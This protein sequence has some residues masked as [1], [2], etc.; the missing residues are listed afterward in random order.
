MVQEETLNMRNRARAGSWTWMGAA[1]LCAAM[2]GFPLTPARAGGGEPRAEAPPVAQA[3]TPPAPPIPG[4]PRMAG[5]PPR[6][7]HAPHAPGLPRRM[8]D[9]DD[10]APRVSIDTVFVVRPGMR[11]AVFNF[12]GTVAF[13]TWPRNA[14]RLA[15]ERAAEDRVAIARSGPELK[16]ESVSANGQPDD[17]D[18]ALTVP[19]WL[20]VSLTGVNSDVTAEGMAGG[21][22]VET[23]HGD[24]VV[25]HVTGAVGLHSVEGV[26]DLADAHGKIDVGSVNDAV[27]LSDITGDISADAVNGDVHLVGVDSR[28]VDATSVSGDVVYDAPLQLGGTYSFSTHDGDIAVGLPDPPNAIVNVSTFSGDFASAFAIKP[29]RSV[30]GKI[31]HFTLGDGRAKLNLE[32]FEGSIELLRL[33]Q[34]E[35]QR[36]IDRAQKRRDE[37]L[38]K[39]GEWNP[40]RRME[41]K[42]EKIEREV[43]RQKRHAEQHNAAHSSDD[44]DK[45]GDQP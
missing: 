12:G 30:G 31:L 9:D 10:D 18:F 42:V 26:V 25:R 35:L 38:H 40:T 44:D 39:W 22:R 36:R 11:L 27:R 21:L 23:V 4:M 15:V 20:P 6:A 41:L 43:E 34:G 28:K 7:P 24:V 14:V 37:S 32:S 1:F 3:P 29:E 19:A 5:I 45:D 2:G 16:F 13:R 17:M 8:R 33:G